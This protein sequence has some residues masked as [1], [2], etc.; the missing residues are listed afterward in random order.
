MSSSRGVSS[1]LDGGRVVEGCSEDIFWW[2]G[3]GGLGEFLFLVG[4]RLRVWST[5][6]GLEGLLVFFFMYSG[7]RGCFKVTTT[8][9]HDEFLQQ[10]I[11][12][13]AKPRI[14]LLSF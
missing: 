3:V 1:S 8:R 5:V 14:M 12:G 10:L 6:E 13:T 9:F 7:G 11:L 4:A 2:M